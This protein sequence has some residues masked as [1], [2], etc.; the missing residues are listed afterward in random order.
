[1]GVVVPVILLDLLGV[2][3]GA[4]LA[5]FCVLLVTVAIVVIGLGVVGVLLVVSCC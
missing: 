1:M 4:E 3:G 5:L 2:A